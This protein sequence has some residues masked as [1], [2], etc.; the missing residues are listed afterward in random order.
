[1][2]NFVKNNNLLLSNNSTATSNSQYFIPNENEWVKSI[3]YDPTIAGYYFYA[4]RNNTAPTRVTANSIG[5][6]SAGPVGNFANFNN[7]AIWNGATGNVTTVGSNGG[8]SYYGIFDGGG[9]VNEWTDGFVSTNTRRVRG[10]NYATT[11]A[12]N[13]GFS[14][15]RTITNKDSNVGF[16]VGSYTN[17]LNLPNFVNIGDINNPSHYT[18]YGSVNYNYSVCSFQLTNN[19]YVD[20]LNSVAGG[21]YADTYGLYS[22]TMTSNVRGGIFRGGSAGS[23]YYIVKTNMGNK[24]VNYVSYLSAIRYCNW[25]TNGKP[26]GPQNLATTEDGTYF[27]NGATFDYFSRK[28]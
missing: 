25:L 27:I 19:E 7:G 12:P 11:S 17:T 1:M 28:T 6:G 18:G 10:G 15:L 14:V 3:H 4:T 8:S 2:N 20:F 16:R 22:S 13:I 26:T 21:P 5:D 23:Y 9:N 24:P